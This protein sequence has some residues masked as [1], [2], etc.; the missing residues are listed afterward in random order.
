[1]NNSKTNKKEPMDA[2]D[3]I[4]MAWCDKTSFD[5][6][7]SL[8]GYTES[9]VKAFMKKSLKA[10]SYRLWRERVSGRKAKH[11]KRKPYVSDDD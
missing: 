6:I 8:T 10:S 3:I 2:H 1:M 4:S 9:E 5:T 7:Y 11:A